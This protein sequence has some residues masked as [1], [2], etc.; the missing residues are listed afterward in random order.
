MEVTGQLNSPFALFSGNESM[1]Q[2]DRRLGGPQSRSGR[3]EV[4]ENLLTLPGIEPWP[5]ILSLYRT[6]LSE[7]GKIPT[8]RRMN[9]WESDSRSLQEHGSRETNPNLVLLS[10]RVPSV[11]H[12]NTGQPRNVGFGL[13][14]L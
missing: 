1:V 8:D 7:S 3:C 13:W 6:G 2:S 10:S 9:G 4:D 11:S 14:S 12:I 5:F